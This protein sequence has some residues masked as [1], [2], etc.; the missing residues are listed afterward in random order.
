MS[1]LVITAIV[2]PSEEPKQLFL[3]DLLREATP[4]RLDKT[5]TMML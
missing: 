1:T 5:N 4:E 3:A 2:T